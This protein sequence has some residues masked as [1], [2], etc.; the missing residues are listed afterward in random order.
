[1]AWLRGSTDLSNIAN[2]LYS[3]LSG[4]IPASKRGLGQNGNGVTVSGSDVWEGIDATRR[5][6]RSKWTNKP[7]EEF[8]S[9]RGAPRISL[10]TSTAI[11]IPNGYSATLGK[12]TFLGTYTGV[13][14]AFFS[15]T[16]TTANT[17]SGSLNG[18]V[19][20][21]SLWNASTGGAI[22]SA[23]TLSGW[24]GTTDTKVLRDGISLTL[25]LSA[26]EQFTVGATRWQRGY[27]ST[28]TQGVDYWIDGCRVRTAT[29][30]VVSNSSGGSNN[31][32]L[33]TDYDIV[34]ESDPYPRIPG[35]SATVDSEFGAN[36]FTGRGGENGVFSGIHWRTGGA[37]A[38]VGANYYVV[39]C[40]LYAAY[41][42][43]DAD[44]QY[45]YFNAAA[46]HD[47]VSGSPRLALSQTNGSQGSA[48]A[49]S[50]SAANRLFSANQS[51]TTFINYWISVKQNKIVIATR[52]DTG[53]T[54]FTNFMT[55]QTITPN[56]VMYDKVAWGMT[57]SSFSNNYLLYGSALPYAYPK[58]WG[59][60]NAIT[61]GIATHCQYWNYANAASINFGP[62]NLPS[63][64]PNCFNG[65]RWSF[66]RIFP[67]GVTY[68]WDYTIPDWNGSRHQGTRG[69]WNGFAALWPD[70]LTNLDEIVDGANTYLVVSASS[71]IP[72]FSISGWTNYYAILEE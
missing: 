36:E 10:R 30:V 63:V 28:W 71:N 51:S 40:D 22:Q 67:Y 21:W 34:Q 8:T 26:G 57:G 18:T 29:P 3:L 49:T 64:A 16:V 33:S 6:V 69:Y 27:S 35:S 37:P 31:F 43:I 2:D 1:M 66:F 25:T 55:F 50:T 58:S 62:S 39:D 53:V 48:Y 38:A 68:G 9:W 12:P 14:K 41:L 44:L 47:P 60:T 45:L 15:V 20:T 59:R 23:T 70:N 17:S 54:T 65:N 7:L 42:K 61:N 52:G 46:Y 72:G 32:T 4:A 13:T 5:V 19:V 56:D 24:T 11:T